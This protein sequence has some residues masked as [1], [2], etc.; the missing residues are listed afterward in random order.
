MEQFRKYTPDELQY[1]WRTTIDPEARKLLYTYLSKVH[2]PPFFPMEGGAPTQEEIDSMEQDYGLYPSLDDPNFHQKLLQKLEFA[3]NK[4]D[5]ITD[6]DREQNLCGDGREF[7]LSAVQRFVARFL[8]PECPY[9][10]AL[11]YHG[12][13]VGKTC[14]AVSI[15]ENYLRIFPRKKVIV[16]A[17]PNIQPNFRNTIFNLNEVRIPEDENTPNTHNGCT[18]N[19]YLQRTGTEFVKEISVI[20]TRVRA[21]IDARYEFMGYIQFFRYI[22]TVK[23][24][25]PKNWKKAVRQA[26]EGR[27]VIIDEA[28][29]LRDVPGET[30]DDNLDVAGGDEEVADSV[31]G[32]RLRPSLLDVLDTCYG[33]KLVLLTA[34]PMY[35]NYMEIA[36]LLELLLRNDK[37]FERKFELTST[38]FFSFEKGKFWEEGGEE[39]L[40][41]AAGAYISFMRGEN[42]LTFPV[43]LAPFYEGGVPKFSAWPKFAPNVAAVPPASAENVQKLPLV[44]VQFEGD[45]VETYLNISQRAVESAGV[46]VSSIDTMVQSGNWLFPARSEDMAP[47]MRIRDTGFDACFN[48]TTESGY[49]QYA[50]T[51]GAPTWLLK[52]NLGAVSPKAKFVLNSIQGAEGVIFIYSRFIK[53][54]ALPLVLA[55]EANGYTPYGRN[56]VGFLK[57]GVQSPDGLQCA[58]CP[59]KSKQ[60]KGADHEFVRATYVL[61]TGKAALSPNNPA[62]VA[63]AVA[64]SG[65]GGVGNEN[66]AQVKVIIGSQ[67]A[68]EGIDLKYIREIYVFDSWF[69]L[70]KM[71]QVLGRG[72]RTCS[73]SRLDTPKQNTTIYLMVNQF[74]EEEDRETADMYMYRIAMAK[75]Q[76]IGKVSRILKKY[77]LDCN[78]NIDAIKIRE[79]QLDDQEHID[80][81]GNRRTVELHDVPF[82]AV[83]D[84]IEEDQCDYTCGNK[85]E[86]DM[87][88]LDT[89]TYDEYAAAWHES[90]LKQVIRKIFQGDGGIETPYFTLEYLHKFVPTFQALPL[91]A[92]RI[93]MND[94]VENQ[95]FRIR[96]GGREGYIVKRNKYYLFQPLEISRIDIPVALRIQQYPVK[97]DVFE[98]PMREVK[99][100]EVVSVNIWDSFTAWAMTIKDGTAGFDIPDSVKGLMEARI[101]NKSELEKEY[102]RLFGVV[103]LYQSMKDNEPWRTTLANVL[104]GLV[105]DE[106]LNPQEQ[107]KELTTE[108]GRAV[109]AAA[110]QLMIKGSREAFRYVEPST[111]LLKYVC[112][113]KPCDVSVANAF[114]ADPADPLNKFE[115]N[116]ATMGVPYGFLVPNLKSSVLVF[117]TTDKP[118]ASG[119]APPKGGVCDIVTQISHHLEELV[120]IGNLLSEAGFPRFGLT[121]EDFTGGRKFQNASRACS[122][123][124]VVLRWMDLTGVRGKRWFLRPVAAYKSKHQVLLEKPKKPRAK[125]GSAAVA[126]GKK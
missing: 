54:G 23:R 72:V 108:G 71:E 19:F 69:H 123:K 10:S 116:M 24:S 70:N 126:E 80:A 67:V 90:K 96:I 65:K 4:Q 105:W 115:A 44:P 111:G 51:M 16:V 100:A 40:A 121:M 25:N 53:S 119:K 81:H 21:T 106:F 28:H 87:T 118:A 8:A 2:T 5:S 30:A 14:A 47:E 103:W 56:R 92:L 36:S 57:D 117:K 120:K 48:E 114:D 43:R 15:A 45:S 82:T 18:G 29:N 60:H 79:G 26:F 32:K 83:C 89:S 75:A 124:N 27:M 34:T 52:E 20:K 76:Q 38:D 104:L 93:L 12:V 35:N 107:L 77:A 6:E 122:I 37:R 74:P 13:G 46:G 7:E 59:L 102:Q 50:S 78:L 11:L 73:H 63:A 1:L 64:K 86:I 99:R 125:K 55:L 39:K 112:G 109:A 9:Q 84:W 58:L 98:P 85:V 91:S 3:E 17:P 88:D 49:L 101:P 68:S 31:G 97:R 42:P 62:M 113:D 66:G 110:Q 22:E 95:S 94:I 33:I 61:L 41:R